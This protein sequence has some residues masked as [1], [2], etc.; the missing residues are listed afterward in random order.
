MVVPDF[1][2]PT[3][4]ARRV[5]PETYSREDTIFN[6]QRS[7]LLIA[8]LATGT[9]GRFPDCAGR[10]DAS[11]LSCGSGA[12]PRRDDS[13]CGRRVCSAARLSGAG[14]SI[15]VFHERGHEEASASWC[16]RCFVNRA[17]SRR[18]PAAASPPRVTAIAK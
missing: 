11:A 14:P 3:V 12:G 2:L 13:S 8:A 15:L 16:G 6:V 5:L 4:E 18:S 1:V 10:P 9:T 17:A 7:A